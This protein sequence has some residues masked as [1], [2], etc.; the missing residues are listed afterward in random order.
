ML[1][2]RRRLGD[3]LDEL[4]IMSKARL[5]EAVG[6][7]VREILFSVA[8]RADGAYAFEEMGEGPT[9]SAGL[10]AQ[11]PPGQMILEAA[12]RLQSPEMMTHVL[13]DIDRV[14]AH[15]SNSLLRVQKLTLSPADG[16]VLSRVDGTLTAREVFQIIPLPQEDTERSLFGLLCTGTLEFIPRT[17]TSRARAAVE[18]ERSAAAV[19]PPRP[20][21]PPARPPC[22]GAG[23]PGTRGALSRP[24]PRPRARPR[25]SGIATT[26]AGR[27]TRAGRRSPPPTRESR[28]ATSSSSWASRATRTTAR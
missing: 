2:E 23:P 27:S 6:L 3:V 25:R 18:A 20:A 15:S 24:G 8:G 11:I 17:A 7:H 1:R 19:P 4:G 22:A 12:R 21:P 9:I 28:R 26:C 14:L 10:T 5:E 16:F 13:G